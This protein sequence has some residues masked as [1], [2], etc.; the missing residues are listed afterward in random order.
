M[1]ISVRIDEDMEARVRRLLAE[2]G[3][4]LSD[5]VRQAIAEKLDREAKKPIADEANPSPYEIGKH[6]FGKYKSGIDDLGSN[7]EKYLR[8][9]FRIK[10]RGY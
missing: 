5:F 1:T 3:G 9:K 8:K 6:L 10:Q 2:H 4:S 7:H